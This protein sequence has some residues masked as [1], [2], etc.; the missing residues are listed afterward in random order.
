VDGWNRSVMDTAREERVEYLD[1][2]QQMAME[3]GK[4]Q[5]DGFVAF[6]AVNIPYAIHN[7]CSL[8]PRGFQPTGP[9]IMIAS[10]F[11]ES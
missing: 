1:R 2:V 9:A 11:S 10:Y 7:G 4:L 5:E 6:S 8:V 3:P